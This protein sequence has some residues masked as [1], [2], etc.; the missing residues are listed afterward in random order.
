LPEGSY[1]LPSASGGHSTGDGRSTVID[2][3]EADIT[4]PG[5][6]GVARVGI[7][8]GP[9]DPRRRSTRVIDAKANPPAAPAAPKYDC[10]IEQGWRDHVLPDGTIT[11][12]PMSRGR[13]WGPV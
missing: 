12:T 6:I 5:E 2:P 8:R 4:P 3:V 7:E 11:P 10:D 9:D 1:G 13:W